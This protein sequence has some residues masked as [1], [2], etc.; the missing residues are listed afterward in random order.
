MNYHFT[1][2]YVKQMSSDF[3]SD[4]AQL[5]LRKELHIFL[6]LLELQEFKNKQYKKTIRFRRNTTKVH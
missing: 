1:F 4:I 2:F 5:T 6:N 3:F